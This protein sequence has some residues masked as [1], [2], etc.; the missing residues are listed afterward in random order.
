MPSHNRLVLIGNGFDLAH[1]LKTSYR[2]FIDWYMCMAFKK[3]IEVRSYEDKLI[4][5]KNKYVG[6]STIYKNQ[7]KSFNEVIEFIS[8]NDTQSLKFNSIILERLL[9]LFE[10]GWVD[11]EHQ[12]FQ[13]LKAIFSL[14]SIT[15]DQKIRQVINLNSDFDHIIQLLTEYITEVNSQ[16]LQCKKI[17]VGNT[18][19]NLY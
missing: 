1:G 7:P 6:Q 14:T 3:F 4:A 13:K 5:I 11:I 16:I 8:C 9:D 19:Y 17:P 10:K 2:N 15:Q 18:R 12:Y